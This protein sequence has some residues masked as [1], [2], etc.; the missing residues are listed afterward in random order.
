LVSRLVTLTHLQTSFLW[1]LGQQ[2]GWALVLQPPEHG[3]K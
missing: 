3:F 2:L 1:A